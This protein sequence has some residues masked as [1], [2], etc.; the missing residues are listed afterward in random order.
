MSDGLTFYLVD[1]GTG[2][3]LNTVTAQVQ[4]QPES[5]YLLISQ[6]PGMNPPNQPG[7]ATLTWSSTTASTVQVR[8]GSP[9][10]SLFTQGGA[11]GS[12]T[13]GGWVN[14]GTVF[15]LQD[16]SNGQPLTSQFTIATQTAQFIP[17]TPTASFQA[18][19]NPVPVAPGT[20]FA[21]TTFYWT[22]IASVITTEIHIG[23]PNGPLFA[24][25]STSGTATASGWVADGTTF[26]LQDVTK[27]KA[28][29]S[30]NTLG[31]VTVHLQQFPLGQ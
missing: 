20:Q 13:A 31:I 11:Q 19:P 1:A 15:Y 16:V 2:V 21:S 6:N 8:I 29:T 24:Q 4:L 3:T 23:A 18:S 9:S 22:A 5:G 7:S 14:D 17:T 30:L 28:L 10:G 27:G 12:A 26:Y 25:G